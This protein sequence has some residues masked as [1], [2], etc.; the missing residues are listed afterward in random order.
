MSMLLQIPQKLS[1]LLLL[2]GCAAFAATA[3]AQTTTW[4]QYGANGKLVYT[5]NSRGDVIPD[6][7]GVGYKNSEASIP[8]VAVAQTV[9]PVSGDDRTNIQN[10]INAVAAMPLQSNGFRGAVLISAGTYEVNS[11][12]NITASGIVIRGQGFGTG[13]TNIIATGT[14]QYNLFRFNGSGGVTV[15]ESTRRAI[16]GSYVPIGA[17]QVTLAS[18]HSF[19]V[20][21]WVLLHHVPN[22]AWIDRIGM[23]PYWVPEDY[24][25]N[26]ERQVVAVAGNTITLDA[27]IMD[28]I[29]DD[30]ATASLVKIAGSGRIENCG[31][32]NLRMTSVYNASETQ[33][34][35][36]GQVYLSDE[37]HG[38]NAVIFE[39]VKNAWAKDLEAH[40]FGYSC[41]NIDS[42]QAIFITVDNCKMLSPVS[43]PQGGRRY[44]FANNGQR[45]LVQNCYAS[46]GRHDFVSGSHTAGPNVYYN[47]VAEDVII[48][49]DSG[50]HHRWTAGGLY[51]RIV[52][53]MDINV[54]NRKA[55]GTGHGWAG[56][57]IV[58]WNCTDRKTILQNPPGHISWAI[59]HTGTIT[60][61]GQ[62]ATE[63][64]G[65]VQSHGTK[66]T[67]IPSLFLAQLSDRLGDNTW[68]HN[69][70][71]SFNGTSTYV[72][73]GTA[74]G[75]GSNLTVAFFAT[76]AKLAN[77]GVADK[78]PASGTSGWSLKLRSDGALWFRIG[79]EATK[80][81]VIASGVYTANTRVHIAAT[82]G[83]GT[84]R[85]YR[86]GVQV[87]T[88]SGITAYDVANT[89]TNLRLGIPS[90]AATSNIY[91]GTLEQVKVYDRVLSA[92]E[93]S[94]LASFP[95][96]VWGH[97]GPT[98]FTGSNSVSGTTSSGSGS[99][100]TIAF[101]ATPS[102]LAN[103]G[104]VDKL[105]ASGSAGWSVKLRSDGALWF[106]IGSE[107]TKTDSVAT[108]V[109]GANT[110]VHVACTFS[111]G[112][113]RIYVNGVLRT[114]TSSIT[115]GVNNTSTTLRLGIPSVAATSNVYTGVL[116]NVEI[117]HSALNASQISVLATEP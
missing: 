81:D 99:S 14:S 101:K 116:K 15:T 42:D 28:P 87:A 38:W 80:Q 5:P 117:F 47:C 37:D 13:G 12:I 63:P 21:D 30:Y 48:N 72:D 113:A 50:P 104:P 54:Q 77:M 97:S 2:L 107:A 20:G 88:L 26:L 98:T 51:D 100:L 109:Y 93:V 83:G 55:S 66:I 44:S 11:T 18:S 61:V 9:T 112:T 17:K 108:G 111:G 76:P 71:T 7:S 40:R 103:M 1:R 53:D 110:P 65:V 82:F 68:L 34:A 86:N 78:L 95:A 32:E 43:Q 31:I 22:Q 115:Y 79:S 59:G 45:N 74:P 62:Y 41:V 19:A 96:L 56:A 90:A 46:E 29:E 33:A 75:S 92:T 85:I 16:T 36:D 73:G 4:V 23:G 39:R 102:Q 91:Q 3:A 24:D 106:R 94:T 35:S 114:T 64:L 67:A 6:F 52:S 105:P 70:P 58:L 84:A 57:Q 60:N 89:V 27:P 49:C 10:A 69:G 8:V 25:Y